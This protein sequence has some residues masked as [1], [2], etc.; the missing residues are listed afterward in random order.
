MYCSDAQGVG[1]GREFRKCKKV[2]H[3][4]DKMASI[5]WKNKR[6]ER[7]IEREFKFKK[8]VREGLTEKMTFQPIAEEWVS[9]LCGYMWEYVICKYMI[10]AINL[11]IYLYVY[12]HVFINEYMYI[13]LKCFIKQYRFHLWRITIFDNQF[14]FTILLIDMSTY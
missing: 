2:K 11:Y 6:G 7:I 12:S 13:N 1:G 9:E 4:V 10:N 3:I 8:V 14:Y 5:I